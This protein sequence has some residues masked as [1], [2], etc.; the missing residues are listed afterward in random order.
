MKPIIFFLSFIFS[1]LSLYG[2]GG[3]K[4]FIVIHKGNAIFSSTMHNDSLFMLGASNDLKNGWFGNFIAMDSLG[5][6]DVLTDIYRGEINNLGTAGK[7][8]RLLQFDN[9]RN[10]FFGII[11]DRAANDLLMFRLDISGNLIWSKP[12]NYP[13]IT[14]GV[15]TF[16][17]F[18]LK[19][20]YYIYGDIQLYNEAVR[21]YVLKVDE[22]GNEVYWNLFGRGADW[23][24]RYG[25]LPISDTT[26]ITY[27]Q[28]LKQVGG[29]DPVWYSVYN[30]TTGKEINRYYDSLAIFNYNLFNDPF[31]DGYIGISGTVNE[32]TTAMFPH[33]VWYDAEFRLKRKT[34][35]GILDPHNWKYGQ[36]ERPYHSTMDGDGNIYAA[37]LAYLPYYPSGIYNPEDVSQVLTVTKISPQGDIVWASIDTVFYNEVHSYGHADYVSG[38]NVSSTGSVYVVGFIDAIIPPDTTYRGTGWVVKYDK[39]GCITENCRTVSTTDTNQD[40]AI[41]SL[42]PNPVQDVLNILYDAIDRKARIE[43]YNLM[44]TKVFDLPVLDKTTTVDTGNLPVGFYIVSLLE[45]NKRVGSGKFIKN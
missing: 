30:A 13:E 7:S 40:T 10:E 39:Y 17:I 5:N 26:F 41:F 25:A 14:I 20:S 36:N 27:G 2:Q 19:D 43:I 15:F 12:F 44:G 8:S 18:K 21:A 31:S 29:F 45:N 16:G 37:T 38:I 1:S 6:W 11:H 35:F 23:H 42:Y 33:A 22:D 4:E 34:A 24:E 32:D 9:E 3:F 28:V